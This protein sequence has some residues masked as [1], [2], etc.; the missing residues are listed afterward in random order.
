MVLVEADAVVAEPVHLL[1]GVEVL[2]VGADGDLGL[3]MLRGQ[4]IGQLAADLQMVEIFAVGEQVEDED[5]H[6]G[7]F[8]RALLTLP[9]R[10]PVQV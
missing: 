1:P 8:P 4:R 7:S 3:E 2:G 10:P 5:F 9:Q 6:G